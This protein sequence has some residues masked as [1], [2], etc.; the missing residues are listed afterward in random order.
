MSGSAVMMFAFFRGVRP[1]HALSGAA[2]G[3]T[4]PSVWCG[5]QDQEPHRSS[6]LALLREW[7]RRHRSR[8]SLCRLNSHMLKDV[9]LTYA[10]AEHEANKPFWRL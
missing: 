8:V 1:E 7:R 5:R 2:S 10:E 9:G 4:S 6:R 3:W